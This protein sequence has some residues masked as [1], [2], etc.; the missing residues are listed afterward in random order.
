MMHP[1]ASHPFR[2]DPEETRQVLQ[3]LRRQAEALEAALA[4]TQRAGEALAGAVRALPG[5]RFGAL[6]PPA[7]AQ[8][9]QELARV[10]RFAHALEEAVAQVEAAFQNAARRLAPSGGG[11]APSITAQAVAL[12]AFPFERAYAFVRGVEGG[13]SNHPNDRGGPTNL[14]ITQKTYDDYRQQQGRSQQDVR[15]ITEAEAEEI[16]RTMYWEASGANRLAGPLALVHFDAAVNHGVGNARRFLEEAQRRAGSEDPH[17]ISRAYLEVRAERYLAIIRNDPSQDRFK[18]GWR[19]RLI[20]LSKDI[21]LNPDELPFLREEY[22]GI[23]R[24]TGG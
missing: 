12:E 23:K 24:N 4:A 3:V 10:Q 11:A 7:V 18:E 8:G 14:G 20:R 13:Y 1:N 9:L 22:W 19:N 15:Q 21:G 2:L 17:A 16:Y 5:E 6:W